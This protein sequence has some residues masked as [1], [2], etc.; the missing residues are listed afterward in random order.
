MNRAFRHYIKELDRE[1][2]TAVAREHSYRPALVNLLQGLTENNVIAVNEAKRLECGAPDVTLL[3]DSAPFAYVECKDIG[4]S[5]DK[6]EKSDQLKRYFSLPNL[7]LTDYLEFRWYQSGERH[8]TASLGRLDRHHIKPLP[9]QFPSVQQ[10][11]NAF[12]FCDTPEIGTTEQLA[13]KMADT[14]QMIRDGIVRALNMEDR[15]GTLHQQMI[16][17]RTTLLRDITD[18][19]FADMYAQTICYGLFMARVNHTSGRFTREKAPHLLPKSNPFLRKMFNYIAGIELDDRIVWAVDHLAEMFHNTDVRGILEEFRERR[20]GQDPVLHFYE[21]F[22]AAYDPKLRRSRG[23]YYTPEPVVSYIVRSVDK[24]L[25]RDFGLEGGLADAAKI[26][27]AND[28]SEEAGHS[29]RSEESLPTS[30]QGER[31]FTS[32]RMTESNSQQIHKVQILDPAVGTGSFLHGVVD[33]IRQSF[34]GNEGMWSGYV[35]NDLL[36]RLFGFELLMAPYTIAHLKVGMLLQESGYEFSGEQRLKIYLT[37]SLEEG[38]RQIGHTLSLGFVEELVKEAEAAGD[39]KSDAPVMVVLGNPPYSGHSAN[40]GEWIKELLKPYFTVDGQPLGERN[41]KWLNDDYVK[42]IRFAQHRIER[43]GY[44]VLAFISNHSYLDNPTFRGMRQSLMNTF[45]DVYLLDLH[46]NS[47]KKEKSPDGSKDEN[48]FDIQQGVG[49]GLFVKRHPSVIANEVKQSPATIHHADLWGGREGKYEWLTDND[50]GSTEWNVL[51]PISPFYLFIEKNMDHWEEYSIGW[52]GNDVFSINSV[53]IV[54]AR[55]GLTIKETAE[56]VW[57]TVNEFTNCLPED[58]RYK[59]S[60]PKDSNWRVDLAQNDLKQSGMSMEKIV[61]IL[62][63]PFDVKYTY[64]T[65]TPSGFHTRPR[66]AVMRNMLAGENIGLITVRQVAEGIF[67]HVFASSSIVESRITLSNKGIGYLYPLY[68]YPEDEPRRPNI[69]PKFIAEL[70]D[71]IGFEPTPEQ[72]FYYI[73]GLFH[74]PTYRTRFAEFLKM[75]FPRVQLPPDSDLFNEL[76][77]LGEQLVG[78]H[79]MELKG[80][81]SVK[82]PVA[83]DDKV[84]QVRYSAQNGRVWINQVQYFEGVPNDVWEFHIGGVSGVREVAEGSEGGDAELRRAESLRSGGVGTEGDDPVDGGG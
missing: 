48:V 1:R 53:G 4:I 62:Y 14:G 39:V 43:T 42:F 6:T 76:C 34:V 21:D 36:P 46:G 44:G 40:K 38:N 8:L 41:P 80:V 84:G 75:D 68:L 22:L 32:F 59:F 11:L 27:T 67:N 83:G 5:L 55:D 57:E 7:I 61:Q 33:H 60:I 12:I 18:D 3:R 45:D 35:E 56:E 71:K 77:P 10:L 79:L 37:N 16:A 74:S 49:I 51:D 72:I 66:E 28:P 54:T 9:A 31:S 70:S 20:K 65:G 24:I 78:Y 19:K 13:G 81:E 63:R 64:Y 47:K 15:G 73:Y 25:K 82:Y 26:E 23:V 2:S 29:E 58:V 52:R 69:S 30:S 17:F 50:I